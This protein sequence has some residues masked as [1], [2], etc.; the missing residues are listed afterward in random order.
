MYCYGNPIIYNDPTGHETSVTGIPGETIPE[1]PS[2]K[3]KSGGNTTSDGNGTYDGYTPVSTHY[4]SPKPV[5]TSGSG[6]S[7]PTSS[8]SHSGGYDAWLKQA[9]PEILSNKGF[10]LRDFQNAVDAAAARGENLS[11][12]SL[13]KLAEQRIAVNTDPIS[14][15]KRMIFDGFMI[16]FTGKLSVI[17]ESVVKVGNLKI[18]PG[19]FSES[20]TYA[21]MYLSQQGRNV[22]LR[23]ATGLG[24]TSD[25][26]VDG[27]AY[28]VYTPTT[29]N[30][31]RIISSI[32]HKN[33]Q[34]TGIVL[35]L[36]SSSVTVDQLRNALIRVRGAGAKNITDIIIIK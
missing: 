16:L 7:Q 30:V 26:L 10:D 28:D 3:K 1:G 25:L 33:T 32:A 31:N 19:T 8:E 24:R 14:Q 15:A 17:E 21:A 36:R 34:A 22:I 35:D 5:A 18:L 11:I 27:I 9:S 6:S 4:E 23:S 12:D 13:N 20:E 29:S 2:G